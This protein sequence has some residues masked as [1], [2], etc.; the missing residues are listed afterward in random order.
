MPNVKPY[1]INLN[2]EHHAEL[3]QI[4]FFDQ[5]TISALYRRIVRDWFT[6]QQK[7]RER[8][9]KRRKKGK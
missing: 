1:R 8:A 3:R 4:A 6:F 9:E 2:P 7:A 5:T